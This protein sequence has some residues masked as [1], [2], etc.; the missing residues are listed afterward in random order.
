MILITMTRKFAFEPG[1][2]LWRS[3]TSLWEFCSPCH[4]ASVTMS[5]LSPGL[6]NSGLVAVVVV[7]CLLIF[8]W[9]HCVLH[10]SLNAFELNGSKLLTTAKL[11]LMTT[12]VR[13]CSKPLKDGSKLRF[14]T[15]CCH[16]HRSNSW[17]CYTTFKAHRRQTVYRVKV[18]W[19][20]SAD[21]KITWK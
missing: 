21:G 18:F 4:S 15:W 19:K 9:G 8:A 3:S 5:W 10:N 6:H 16:I 1:Y 2:C 20:D 13:D 11:S 7:F 17:Q 12:S 14:I